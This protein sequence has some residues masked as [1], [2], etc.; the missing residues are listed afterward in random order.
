MYL[1]IQDAESAAGLLIRHGSEK[2][3]ASLGAVKNIP[4]LCADLNI[5]WSFKLP[6]NGL[7]KLALARGGPPV[8]AYAHGQAID[9]IHVSAGKAEDSPSGITADTLGEF[10]FRYAAS[11]ES[12]FG[13]DRRYAIIPLPGKASFRPLLFLSEPLLVISFLAGGAALIMGALFFSFSRKGRAPVIAVCATAPLIAGIL[14]SAFFD[15]GFLPIWGGSF[16]FVLLGFFLRKPL[17]LF[18]CTLLAYISLAGISGALFISRGTPPSETKAEV[19]ERNIPMTDP[20]DE[21][22]LVNI[23][24]RMQLERQ[25]IDLTLRSAEAPIRFDLSLAGDGEPFLI[26]SAPMPYRIDEEQSSAEFFLGEG[27]PNPLRLEIILSRNFSGY[28]RAEALF[29]DGKNFQR[30]VREIPVSK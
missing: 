12:E 19:W 7:Y 27:P 16:F 2:G 13:R 20:G 3:I 24:S 6:F 5:P 21:A 11:L 9:A 30:V 29:P 15:I 8:L 26:Y 28:L 25:I 4:G 14:I 18:V 17:P 23:Q 10:I 22:L 1:D